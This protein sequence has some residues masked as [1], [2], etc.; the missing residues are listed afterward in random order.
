[1]R[2]LAQLCR[3]EWHAPALFFELSV[4]VT[5]ILRAGFLR[6]RSFHAPETGTQFQNVRWPKPSKMEGGNRSPASIALRRFPKSVA[7][8]GGR[9]G[10]LPIAKV[11]EQGP[12]Q[13]RSKAGARVEQGWSKGL[14]CR[15]RSDAKIDNGCIAGACLLAASALKRDVKVS[16][17]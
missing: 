5:T 3:G 4:A 9:D 12:E 15:P 8:F 10:A 7:G 2:V 17:A 11:P 14:P 13:G 16:R 1:M 6:L